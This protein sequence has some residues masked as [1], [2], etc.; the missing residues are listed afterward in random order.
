MTA[1]VVAGCPVHT[2]A[3]CLPDYLRCLDSQTRVPDGYCFVVND[4]EDNSDKILYDWG[5]GR[6]HILNLGIV[7]DAG[8][9]QLKRRKNRIYE[10]LA[11][12]R[13]KLME[14]AFEEMGADYLLSADC[15]IMLP[16]Y[17][18]EKL[19]EVKKDSVACIISNHPAG[20]LF[21]TN[22][23]ILG[24][25]EKWS[26]NAP[27][28]SWT[29]VNPARNGD[30]VKVNY[31]GAAYLISRRLYESDVRYSY[32]TGEEGIRA[33]DPQGEDYF[34]CKS[35]MEKGIEL[36]VRTDCVAFHC[37]REESLEEKVQRCKM[38]DEMGFDSLEMSS[39]LVL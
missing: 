6:V 21:A 4:S 30:L 17:T 12:T 11:I 26:P 14:I 7:A 29:A 25:P 20:R 24:V 36:W 22:N 37:M 2:R 5:K 15:D 10:R 33:T 19:L 13:N 3:W 9:S 34:F 32:Y 8:R 23:A 18:L 31:T 27:P 28:R 39:C 16:K 35:A 1:K 38:Y